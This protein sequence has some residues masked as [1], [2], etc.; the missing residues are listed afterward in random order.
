MISSSLFLFANLII[1]E[2][3]DPKEKG[4]QKMKF[5]R[6]KNKKVFVAYQLI[7]FLFSEDFKLIS[8]KNVEKS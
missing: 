6:T 3:L 7:N 8:S 2:M 1:K 5:K 4:E